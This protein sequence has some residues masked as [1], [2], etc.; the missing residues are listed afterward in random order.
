MYVTLLHSANIKVHT[1]Q[2][3]DKMSLFER[4]FS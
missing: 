4:C 2:Y 1:A 3:D